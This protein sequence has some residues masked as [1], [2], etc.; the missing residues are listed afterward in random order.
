[1]RTATLSM[2]MV[3]DARGMATRRQSW[4][5]TNRS[6]LRRL[7]PGRHLEG[8][9]TIASI[10]STAQQPGIVSDTQP[11]RNELMSVSQRLRAAYRATGLRGVARSVISYFGW[12]LRGSPPEQ[13]SEVPSLD[14]WHR[15]YGSLLPGSTNIDSGFSVICPVFNAPPDLL[16]L[17]VGSVL[18]Q[19]HENW[20]LILVDDASTSSATKSELQAIGTTDQRITVV[21]LENNLGI[22]GATNHGASL[23]TKSH[24]VF[25]DHDDLLARSALSWLASAAEEADLIYTDED[26][27]SEEGQHHS[28]FFKPDWSPRLLLSVNYINHITCVRRTTFV[29]AGGLR[30]GF[31]GVQDHDLLLRLAETPGLRVVHIPNLLYHWRAWADSTSARPASKA[32]VEERGVRMIQEALDRRG[33]AATAGLG[34]GAPFNYR[35]YFSEPA[36]NHLV[37]VVMPTRDRLELLR[38]SVRGLLERTDGVDIHLVVVDNG[39]QERATL[40][41][42]DT[43]AA[44]HEK[45]EVIRRDDAFNY[46]RLCNEGA[47]VGPDAPYLLFLN[48]DVEVIHRRWLQQLVG[49]LENDEEVLAVGPKLLFPDRTIQ[50]AGVI[51]GFGGI[52][53]HYASRL[54]NQPH[55][56]NLHDQV[57]E[58]GC[59]TAACLLVRTEAFSKV[60]E[61]Y[62][63]LPTDFQDV[64]FCLRLR[65][66]LGGTLLYDPT[67]PLIHLQS[68]SRGTLGAASGY[69]VA[70]MEFLWGDELDRGDPFYS[71]HL[72]RWA[73]DFR[74]ATIPNETDARLRRLTPGGETR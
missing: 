38:K 57:R 59:L 13:P 11:P 40:E 58:V 28:P 68:A 31:D 18:G 8:S 62:E 20:E 71:P 7:Q 32:H 54:P 48:N 12:R 4:L 23:A 3:S 34:N 44:G 16:R 61:F 42:L 24:L 70:R 2:T 43:L 17:C 30:P 67:Y 45:V 6:T 66:E 60:G 46:S 73:H 29:E 10:C 22:A 69:T 49:W 64:D 41:Y 74:L 55:S 26:K 51:V 1:M 21:F 14:E 53:G 5:C 56:G 50:H 36:E 25:L 35:P 15:A 39:S 63:W 47:A 9:Q 37:K 65:T 72:S 33:W 52:A 27:V 19:T